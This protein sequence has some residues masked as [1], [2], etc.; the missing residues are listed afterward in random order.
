MKTRGE[1]PSLFVEFQK[2]AENFCGEK[3]C[4]LRV[5]NAPE[6]IRGGLQSHCKD[7]GI[8]YEKTV[9]DSPPQ[10]GVAERTNRTICSMARA[11]LIDANLRDY[12][13]PFAVLAAAHIKQRLPHS[14][15]PPN[16][17]PF[18]LWFK[19]RADLSHL[20]PFGTKCT[21]RILAP[22]SSKFQPRGETGR[23][24][25]YAKDAKGYLVW[26][27]NP[28]NN[29]GTLKVR[30]D[31][32]FHCTPTPPPPTENDYSPLWEHVDF[33]DHLKTNNDG[34]TPL[35]LIGDGDPFHRHT[36]INP[37]AYIPL[38]RIRA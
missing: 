31:V 29:G 16:V 38:S 2:T 14:S 1:A 20:R 26:V 24:L 30:R 35:H 3:I 37:Y 33:P 18:E 8:L 6:L 23:F 12:F 7:R 21:A 10:N 22:P 32:I 28:D 9:P 4:F 19:K 5:D 25:G 27:P 17:T 34:T 15:L 11:M 13:W 36:P